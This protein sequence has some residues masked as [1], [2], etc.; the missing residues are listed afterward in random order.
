MRHWVSTS[1]GGA[2]GEEGFG[3]PL[4]EVDGESDAVPVVAGENYHL[5]AAR[6]TQED[7]EHFFRQENRTAP[8]VRDAHGFERGMQMA[9]AAFEPAETICGL[10][11]ANIIAV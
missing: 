8:A 9:D 4:A 11:P 7:G 2:A 6:M 1:A 10:A 5:F 3:G